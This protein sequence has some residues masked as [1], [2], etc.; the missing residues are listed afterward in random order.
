MHKEN[1]NTGQYEKIVKKLRCPKEYTFF[2]FAQLGGGR[3]DK[4]TEVILSQAQGEG[5]G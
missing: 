4:M 3:H 5:E 2:H 1:Y